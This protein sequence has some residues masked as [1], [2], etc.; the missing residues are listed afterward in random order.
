MQLKMAEFHKK[1]I[2][3]FAE[4]MKNLEIKKNIDGKENILNFIIKPYTRS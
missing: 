2:I 4:F 3:D 1:D